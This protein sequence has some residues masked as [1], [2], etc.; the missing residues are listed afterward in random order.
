MNIVGIGTDIVD[1]NRLRDAKHLRRVADFLFVP[2]ELTDMKRSK[3]KVQFVA[4]RLALKESVI[5][6]YPG[7]LHYHDIVISK[8][9]KKLVV[10]LVPKKAAHY[11][12]FASIAH[13]FNCAIGYAILCES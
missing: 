4:S 3:D 5:K 9:G 6:A 12:V 7:T 13:E 8:K 10:K 1:M 11:D 2:S